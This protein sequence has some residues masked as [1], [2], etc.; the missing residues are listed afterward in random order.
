MSV[1]E[2]L[3]ESFD[4]SVYVQLDVTDYNR[5]KD[6]AKGEMMEFFKS[7][8][9]YDSDFQRFLWHTD[10]YIACHYW[11]ANA[12]VFF[13]KQDMAKEKFNLKYIADVSCDIDGPIASTIRPS[14]IA[15]PF[16]GIDKKTGKEVALSTPDSLA[17]MAVDNLPCELPIDA[18]V[19]FG[20]QLMNKTIPSLFNGDEEGILERASIANNGELTK[21]F[22]Y[23]SDYAKGK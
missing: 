23:L 16:Y 7:P 5:R 13:T 1:E 22:Q 19:D 15:E 12:P 4:E 8:E 10:Y 9:L 6:G 11:D 2:Y 20:K 18:S 21:D 14:T 3:Q 17:V